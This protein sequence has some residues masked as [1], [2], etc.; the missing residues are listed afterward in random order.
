MYKKLFLLSLVVVANNA[1][2][3]SYQCSGKV[4]SLGMYSGGEVITNIGYGH[5]T[6]CSTTP[7]ARGISTS[8]CRAWYAALLSAK[9]T[10]SNVTVH[11]D[12]Q[13]CSS[14]GDWATPNAFFVETLR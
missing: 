10:D 6:V 3:A 5:W 12:N 4:S 7:A 8:T 13:T 1:A 2:A 14:P 11:L 9:A